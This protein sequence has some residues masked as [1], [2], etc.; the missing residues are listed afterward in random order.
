MHLEKFNHDILVDLRIN[1]SSLDK[2][3][4]QNLDYLLVLDLEGKVEILEFPVVM[5]DSKSMEFVD[6]FHRYI[7]FQDVIRSVAG[8]MEYKF[9]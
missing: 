8:I 3:R 5:I 6:S 2:L 9:D 7:L 1:S 4:P